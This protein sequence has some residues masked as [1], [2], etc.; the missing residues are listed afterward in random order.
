MIP[1]PKLPNIKI[2]TSCTIRPYSIRSQMPGSSFMRIGESARLPEVQHR[3][4]H[5]TW[6]RHVSHVVGV[7]T[8]L[9]CSACSSMQWRETPAMLKLLTDLVKARI[10]IIILSQPYH[11]SPTQSKEHLNWNWTISER[12]PLMILS[13]DVSLWFYK[14]NVRSSLEMSFQLEMSDSTLYI[15]AKL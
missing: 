12:Q 2:L 3:K 15:R 1:F 9:E 8:V 11:S 4:W 10:I 14:C 5:V 6:L 13:S 7:M